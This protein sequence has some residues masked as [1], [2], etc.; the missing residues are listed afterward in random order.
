LLEKDTKLE[1]RLKQTA[2]EK[3]EE[4]QIKWNERNTKLAS[5]AQAKD[6]RDKQIQF[7]AMNEYNS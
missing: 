2:K 1:K 6:D 3:K 4:A 7:K 5:G